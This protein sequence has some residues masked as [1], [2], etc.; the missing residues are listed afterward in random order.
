MPTSKPTA[1]PPSLTD[2]TVDAMVAWMAWCIGTSETNGDNVNFITSWYGEDG[3]PWCD[4]TV[5]YAAYHSG[6]SSHVC[7]N[8][9][10]DYTVEHAT[11][12]YNRGQWH[13]DIA[14]I[15]RGDIVFFDWDGSNAISA[16]DHVGVV[17]SVSADGQT[18]NTI[19]GNIDNVCK[20]MV[21]H[22]DFIAGYGRP[23][24]ALPPVPPTPVPPAP[25][26]PPDPA[27][28]PVPPPPPTLPSVSLKYIRQAATTNPTAYNTGT[29]LVQNALAKVG[30]ISFTDRGTYGPLTKQAYSAWQKKC[31]YTGSVSQPNSD[32]NG[33]PGTDSLGKLA[34]ATGLFV[35]SV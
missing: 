3:Q 7:F 34:A 12:F 33:V 15:Q 24:Y 30:L 11:A 19:E 16:I 6:N 5:T 9:Y 4:M 10:H 13:T 21:R 28:T 17:E 8:Q 2:G 31:G 20:R 23:Q 1:T 32:A 26:P 14:G 18:V 29:R 25:V 22:A 27:P 35:V